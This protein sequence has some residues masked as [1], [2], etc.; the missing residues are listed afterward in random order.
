VK[1]APDESAP[2]LCPSAPCRPGAKVIG[3]V[4]PGPRVGYIEPP[5]PVDSE[6][7]ESAS[8]NGPP[9]QRFRFADECVSC[10]CQWWDGARCG[11]SDAAL[12]LRSAERTSQDLP[13]CGIRPRCQWFAQNGRA[14]CEVCPLIVTDLARQSTA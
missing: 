4:G 13:R 2:H 8:A 9:E 3:V 12:E 7:V 1:P 5:L 10:G 6:F 14:A 11:V